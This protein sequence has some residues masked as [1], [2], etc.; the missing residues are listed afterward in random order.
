MA[1]ERLLTGNLGEQVK[2]LMA[3]EDLL[4]E[5]FKEL[6][7]DE[8]KAYV[9]AKVDADEDLKSELREAV[10]YYFNAKARSVYAELKAT[11]A[12]AKLGLRIL[13]EDLQGEVGDALVG[14][15]EKE[16]GDLLEKAL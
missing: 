2:E 3:T 4:M 9:R 12:A 6:V 15:F 11:R 1:I 5:T 7:K 14:L 10:T 16:L 8:L 13:P